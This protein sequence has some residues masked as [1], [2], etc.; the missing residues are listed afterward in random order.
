MGPDSFKK[1]AP[2]IARNKYCHYSESFLYS[3][4]IYYTTPEKS[5]YVRS[6][7]HHHQREL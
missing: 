3:A 4:K 6:Q 7:L 2:A 5:S 1:E